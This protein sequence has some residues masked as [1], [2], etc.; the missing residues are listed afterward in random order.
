MSEAKIYPNVQIGA[1]AEIGDYVIIGEPPRGKA[2]GEL[3]TIIGAGAVIRSHTVIYAG[4]RIGDHFQTGHHAMI[5]EE[6]TIG[7]DVSIGT[8]SIVEHHVIIEDGVRIHSQAFI[9]EY[10]KLEQGCWLGPNVVL[11]NALHPQCP[12]VKSCLKGATIGRRAKIGANTTILPD[13]AI[14]EDALVGAGSVVTRDVP[15]RAVV[16]GN[17]ARIIK[18]IDDLNCPYDLVERPYL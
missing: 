17:P 18:Q 6:N 5:R 9:P 10:S 11:T 8:G 14:G 16:A 15:A 1:G 13:R 12:K 7:N 4:N 2:P 3:P